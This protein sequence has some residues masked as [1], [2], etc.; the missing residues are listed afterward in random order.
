MMN[1]AVICAFLGFLLLIFC[2]KNY[3]DSWNFM[4]VFVLI[5]I[6]RGISD[7]DIRSIISSLF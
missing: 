3:I 2:S 4:L 6:N 5:E 7:I 1:I